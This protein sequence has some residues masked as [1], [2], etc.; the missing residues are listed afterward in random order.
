MFMR[1]KIYQID[2]SRDERR[3]RFCDYQAAQAKGGVRASEY[4]CVFHGYVVA[5]DLEDVYESFNTGF[6]G[7]HQGHSLSPSDLVEVCEGNEETA[8]GVYFCDRFGFAGLPEDFSTDACAPMEGL[9]VLMI[10]P[11]CPPVET[12]VR[13][14]LKD[15]QRAVSEAGEE[16]LM[17]VTYPYADDGVVIVGDEEAKLKNRAGNRYIGASVYAGT[18]FFVGDNGDGNFCDLTDEQVETYSN[19]FAE[20]EEISDEK[21]QADSG[22][23]FYSM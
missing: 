15:W 21:V 10:E 7:T 2:R 9:R 17:E 1:I 11:N 5:G 12:R 23:F 19:L 16:S 3:L 8:P 4:K 18:I 13:D 14:K 20:P 22:F 6:H